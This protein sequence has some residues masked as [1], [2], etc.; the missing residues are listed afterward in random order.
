MASL[1]R[2]LEARHNEWSQLSSA[3]LHLLLHTPEFDNGTN[4]SFGVYE[5]STA[6]LFT[7]LWG[8]RMEVCANPYR[9]AV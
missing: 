6:M 9:K 8:H 3:H 2:S 4:F 1:M 7:S 5:S